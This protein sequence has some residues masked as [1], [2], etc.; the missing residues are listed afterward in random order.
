MSDSD[1]ILIGIDG[2]AT[3]MKGHLIDVR[4][5]GDGRPAFSLAGINASQKY[6]KSPG[7]QPTDI[8]TQL[9]EHNDRAV[10]PTD[11]ERAETSIWIGAAVAAV[12][13]IAN[14]ARN[15]RA[16]VGMG[17]PGLKTPDGRGI[18]V[19]LNGPRIPNYL[20]LVEQGVRENDIELVQPVH[21]L[22][23]DADYCGI[24]EEYAAG[25]AFQ[26]VQNAY[27][28]G[29][30]T[31][32][33]DALKLGGE[34][35]PLDNTKPWLQK[36]WQIPSAL[37]PTF[38]KLSSAK[39]MNA[40]YAHYLNRPDSYI[41]QTGRYAQEDASRG[42]PV[43][44]GV[45]ETVTSTMAEL[46][47]ERIWTVMNGRQDAPWRGE[48]YMNLAVDHPHRGTRLERIVIGQRLGFVY[49]DDRFRDVFAGPLDA[50]LAALIQE[51]D[52]EDL[53]DF[54]LADGG[55]KD[56]RVVASTLRSAPAIGAG[57]DAWQNAGL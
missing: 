3:E 32:V 20:D 33:A 12:T 27:Y 7:F 54:Y 44:G 2:G 34:L 50:K 39:W 25:G 47:F 56:G 13:E 4:L 29:M 23:S 43:A 37:G 41:D 31:G 38:E 16:L 55:L 48:A 42:N 36:S 6:E 15:K 52:D 22:G 40:T 28:A 24:G 9:K 10:Q 14:K 19:L 26:G 46:I 35:V 21:R 51:S 30:G 1:F 49:A 57:V 18:N 17:M 53:R 45:I 5:E 11:G 8:Q